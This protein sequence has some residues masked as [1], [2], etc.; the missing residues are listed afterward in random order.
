MQL[1]IASITLLLQDGGGANR[2]EALRALN[3]LLSGAGGGVSDSCTS[4]WLAAGPQDALTHLFDTV[5][6]LLAEP[7]RCSSPG[8]A[9]VEAALVGTAEPML[10]PLWVWLAHDEV[11]AATTLTGGAVVFAA[12]L[13]YLAWE[14]R[15]QP[16]MVVE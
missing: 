8:E 2:L 3:H 13:A 4:G 9:R 14:F 6:A 11:P 1:A 16:R 5:A 7:L 10:G 12:L 15:R